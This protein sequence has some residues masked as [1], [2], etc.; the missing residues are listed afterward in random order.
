[1]NFPNGKQFAFA[2]ID[3]TDVATVENIRAVYQELDACGIKATKTVWM[4]RSPVSG[5]FDRSQ[6]MEDAE[7][8]SFILALQKQGFEIAFH[9][10]SME[11][12]RRADILRAL[13]DFRQ[14]FGQYPRVHANHAENRDNLYWGEERFNSLAL[15]VLSRWNAKR[16]GQYAGYFRGH[17]HESEYFWGDACAEHIDYVRNFCFDT[18]N[19]ASYNPS[20]PYHDPRRPFVKFWFSGYDV[21]DVLTFN[22]L[23]SKARLDRLE[24]EGGVCIA[25][26]HFGK[27]FVRNGRLN[28]ATQEIFRDLAGRPGWYPS[29]S[30]LLD[31]LRSRPQWQNRIGGYELRMMEWRWFLYRLRAQRDI[32]PAWAKKRPVS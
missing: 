28:P 6:T 5:N 25:A 24:K 19:Q 7:Y 29:V 4:Q 12:S 3:D 26:T 17:D 20:Q 16:I 22:R 27:Y 21:P 13:D 2:I 11:S 30:E 8:A 14:V 31:H 15:R 10:A 18:I 9:G 32:R 23:L 1:M